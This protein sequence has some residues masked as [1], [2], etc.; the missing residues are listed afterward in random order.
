MSLIRDIDTQDLIARVS[1]GGY[2][3][4][5]KAGRRVHHC[6]RPVKLSSDDP[7]EHGRPP[8]GFSKS[9]RSDFSEILFTACGT[10]RA[11]LCK[12]CSD[13]YKGDARRIIGLGLSR[14]CIQSRR[15][16]SAVFVTFTA[17]S[18]G[19]VHRATKKGNS[20]HPA[21]G[22]C[23]HGLPFG[24]Y[25]HHSDTDE[26]VG[27][28]LCADCY[29]YEGAVVFNAVS[30]KLW[31]RTTI[32]LRRKLAH[33]LG[34]TVKEFKQTFV[35]SYVKVVEF[36]R[37]GLIHL[38]VIIRLDDHEG[39][40]PIDIDSGLLDTAVRMSAVSSSIPSPIGDGN[41]VTWGEQLD[42]KIIDSAFQRKARNYLAKYATKSATD[43]PGLDHRLHSEAAIDAAGCSSHLKEM[44]RTALRLSKDQRYEDLRLDR[45]AHDL[46]HRGHFLTKSRAYSVTFAYLRSLRQAWQVANATD[47]TTF[48]FPSRLY[49]VGSGWPHPIDIAIITAAYDD[50]CFA[51][52]MALEEREEVNL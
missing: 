28:P 44:A 8:F 15:D 23:T 22:V 10:R 16:L 9:S 48:T 24:C 35:L 17:P 18:F 20:C 37:R 52:Q 1:D 50:R 19:S 38:H 3:E 30:G 27:S 39:A 13:L 11:N 32:Y 33:L 49:Y 4:L 31:Q 29:D 21:S 36:Q 2:D 41:H 25:R 43:A 40:H 42:I 26:L 6:S 34:L 14:V 7:K 5:L 51:R 47:E 46:G 45:W 12:A